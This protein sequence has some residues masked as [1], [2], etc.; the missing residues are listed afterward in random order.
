M[1]TTHTTPSAS[2]LGLATAEELVR[3]GGH[4]SILDM[5]EE[6]G[7]SVISRFGSDK[8]RFF[9]C[10][11]TETESIAAAV[12]GTVEWVQ[13]SGKPLGGV[14]PAAGISL[15]STVRSFRLVLFLPSSVAVEIVHSACLFFF[16][17]FPWRSSWLHT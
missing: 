7:A 14:I 10:N 9:R 5:N 1:L 17:T 3:A 2:G 11:V 8:A 16:V 13:Q 4:V 15:P 6:N 12:R